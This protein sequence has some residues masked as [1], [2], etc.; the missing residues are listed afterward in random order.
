MTLN[1]PRRLHRLKTQLNNGVW[2]SK[3]SN[4]VPHTQNVSYIIFT[5]RELLNGAF[6]NLRDVAQLEV[7]M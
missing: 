1:R 6:H 5:A 3:F 7:Y 2:P 4:T